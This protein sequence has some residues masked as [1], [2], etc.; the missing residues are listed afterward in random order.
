MPARRLGLSPCP[1]IF[2]GP[3]QCPALCV[4]TDIRLGYARAVDAGQQSSDRRVRLQAEVIVEIADMA[5]LESAAL[6]DIEAA[7]FALEDG[8]SLAEVRAAQADEVRG[9]PAAAIGWLA[10]PERIFADIPGVRIVGASHETVA[11]DQH[12]FV[13]ESQPDFAALFPV[14]RCGSESCEACAGYQLTPRTAA[15]VWTVAQILAD[16]AY[17]DVEEHGDEPVVDDEDWAVFARYPRL[18]WQQDAVWRR[19]AARSFDDLT[20]DLATGR[21]PR[22]TCAGEEMALRLMLRDVKDAVADGWAGLE[23]LSTRSPEHPDD[24]DW[25]MALEVFFQDTDILDLFD[26]S[27]DGIED[28]HSELN[29]AIGMGDYRPQAWFKPFGNV[30]PRDSRRPFRR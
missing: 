25:D 5:A 16:Q 8:V 18:T 19:Q 7:E 30:T 23:N 29:Q 28:P 2:C 11:L 12:S 22:P 14:C 24:F 3:G 9:D 10:E 26:V 6:A 15:A 1:L 21:W 4:G 20:E 17:D 13:R 27:L